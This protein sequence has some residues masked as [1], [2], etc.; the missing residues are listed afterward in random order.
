M[1]RAF[2]DLLAEHDS[3]VWLDTREIEVDALPEFGPVMIEAAGRLARLTLHNRAEVADDL[4][5]DP[6]EYG[7][8]LRGGERQ[9]EAEQAEVMRLIAA[10]IMVR[11]LRAAREAT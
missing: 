1:R 3:G 11:D 4:G 7:P 5:E 10:G 8:G 9:Y 6:D 2:T